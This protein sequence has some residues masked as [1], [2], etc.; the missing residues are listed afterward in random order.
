MLEF[1][2]NVGETGVGFEG[3]WCVAWL[4]PEDDRLAFFLLSVSAVVALGI[5]PL[6]DLLGAK[7]GAGVPLP[8]MTWGQIKYLQ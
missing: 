4:R 6:L 2:G 8:D 3:T 7:T 1:C 5:L